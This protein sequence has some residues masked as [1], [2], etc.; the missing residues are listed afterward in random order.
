MSYWVKGFLKP[1]WTKEDILSLDYE[2]VVSSEDI[3]EFDEWTS[4]GYYSD[5]LHL[6]NYYHPFSEY[7][8]S[9]TNKLI[10][11]FSSEFFVKNV[12]C[13]FH[14]MNTDT[15][16]PNHSDKYLKYIKLFNCNINSIKRAIIFPFDWK[17][18]HYFEINETPIVNWKAGDFILWKGSTPHLAANFG[19]SDR[20]TIQLTGQ[21]K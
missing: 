2:S 10:D 17:S 15:V 9:T 11:W 19:I 14:R 13:S 21:V 8:T 18:G 20:Y 7:R 5:I 12:G 6:S 3:P 4:L 1:F 16:L